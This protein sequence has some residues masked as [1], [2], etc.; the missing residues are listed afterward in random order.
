MQIVFIPGKGISTKSIMDGNISA[1]FE[2]PDVFNANEFINKPLKL[3]L[4]NDVVLDASIS[5]EWASYYY[6]GTHKAYA[7]KLDVLLPDILAMWL[8]FKSK[9]LNLEVYKEWS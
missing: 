9:S 6:N 8:I 4:D 3:S 2:V 7:I 1:H 5:Q